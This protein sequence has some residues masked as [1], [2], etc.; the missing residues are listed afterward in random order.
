MAKDAGSPMSGMFTRDRSVFLLEH[1]P[2]R[3]QMNI[4]RPKN[5]LR[6]IPTTNK[7][8]P[9]VNWLFLPMV[10]TN[11]LP[12]ALSQTWCNDDSIS[13]ESGEEKQYYYQ[14]VV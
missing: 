12:T 7:V 10:G 6:R 13:F 2:E 5:P 4:L 11:G 3:G 8:M 14:V 9:T 1:P